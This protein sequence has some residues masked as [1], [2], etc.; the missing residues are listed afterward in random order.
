[1]GQKREKKSFSNSQG[2]RGEGV[3]RSE[4]GRGEDAAVT[5]DSQRLERLDGTRGG[6]EGEGGGRGGPGSGARPVTRRERR[7]CK[8]RPGPHKL[9][10][11]RV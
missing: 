10:K 7:C 3:G 4:E 11:P 5:G 8:H 9:G 6:G 1:M 2:G